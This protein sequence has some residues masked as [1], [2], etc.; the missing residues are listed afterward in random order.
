L[1]PN[2]PSDDEGE[3]GDGFAVWYMSIRHVSPP[4]LNRKVN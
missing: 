3:G 4:K 2:I 1:V